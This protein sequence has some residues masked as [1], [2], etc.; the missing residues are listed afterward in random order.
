MQQ[1]NGLDKN[2]LISFVL[3]TLILMGGMFYFQ[4]KQAKEQQL[5]DAENKAKVTQTVQNSPTKPAIVTN[6]ND[7][8][9]TASIQQVELKNKDLTLAI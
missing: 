9:K 2:Q 7:S 4:N 8:V 1:N 5:K 3:F 6:L